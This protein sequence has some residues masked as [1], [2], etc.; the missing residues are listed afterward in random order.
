MWLYMV[1]RDKPFQSRNEIVPFN[2]EQSEDE[3]L[4]LFLFLIYI[5]FVQS[6]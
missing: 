4:P 1:R 6:T 2:E 3:P 5:L